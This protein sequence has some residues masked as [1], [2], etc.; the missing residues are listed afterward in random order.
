MGLFDKLLGK[1][2]NAPRQTPETGKSPRTLEDLP[3]E[4]QWLLGPPP[5]YGWWL[6]DMLVAVSDAHQVLLELDVLKRTIGAS[7]GNGAPSD[8]ER[9]QIVEP[10]VA[11]SSVITVDER[12]VPKDRSLWPEYSHDSFVQTLGEMKGICDLV[13]SH[14][15]RN[16]PSGIDDLVIRLLSDQEWQLFDLQALLTR[17]MVNRMDPSMRAVAMENERLAAMPDLAEYYESVEG[18]DELEAGG[19]K[20]RWTS[21]AKAKPLSPRLAMMFRNPVKY[22]LWLNHLFLCLFQGFGAIHEVIGTSDE[23]VVN[24]KPILTGEGQLED[25]HKDRLMAA[26]DQ[27]A[28]AEPD[29]LQ[30][31][32]M[33]LWP[34]FSHERYRQLHWDIERGAFGLAFALKSGDTPRAAKAFRSLVLERGYYNQLWDLNCLLTRYFL[35]LKS[36]GEQAAEMEK[37]STRQRID[38]ADYLDST[39]NEVPAEDPR[40][41]SDWH[42]AMTRK[43]ANE[44]ARWY[45]ADQHEEA[46]PFLD[47]ALACHPGNQS[48]SYYYARILHKKGECARAIDMYVLAEPFVEQLRENMQTGGA[49]LGVIA[50]YWSG[51]G[52]CLRSLGR[53][54]EALICLDRAIDLS[55]EDGHLWTNKALVLE[56][57]KEYSAAVDAFNRAIELDPRDIT[58]WKCKGDSLDY[59]GRWQDAIHCYDEALKLEPN[60]PDIWVEKATTLL[61][62]G[63][64]SEALSCCDNALVIAPGIS[65]GLEEKAACLHAL[66]RDEE[67]DEYRKQLSSR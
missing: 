26:A 16:R 52:L 31:H 39:G 6:N 18:L 45:H 44:G 14:M 17:F 13:A 10:L 48:A 62:Q 65:R 38:H 61:R 29:I 32:P 49:R 63:F 3:A 25:G 37:K 1:S 24:F 2:R 56:S 57:L 5:D 22:A 43:L 33:P 12:K 67:A 11:L 35:G 64:T 46:G 40:P 58:A 50:Y 66:G 34:G 42:W 20:P 4:H 27:L 41:L 47:L 21:R 55:R 60:S 59:L 19:H 9:E 7:N 15:R 53:Y 8:A 30:P 36:P 54:D 51:R 23:D 28:K